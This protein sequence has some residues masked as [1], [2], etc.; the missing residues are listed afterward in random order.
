[1]SR[2]RDIEPDRFAFP[3]DFRNT[4]FVVLDQT[5]RILVLA[6]ANPNMDLAIAELNSGRWRQAAEIGEYWILEQI[7]D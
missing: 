3:C 7:A 5:D 1:M 6:P 4:K 2:D